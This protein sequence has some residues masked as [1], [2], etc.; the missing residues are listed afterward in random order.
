MQ[1]PDDKLPLFK[2][3]P[4]RPSVAWNLGTPET[5]A[6][7]KAYSLDRGVPYCLPFAVSFSDGEWRNS[8]TG[9]K[10]VVKIEGWR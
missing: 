3:S 9:E 2:A 1:I 8:V 6:K 5:S 4:F 10:I 7:V